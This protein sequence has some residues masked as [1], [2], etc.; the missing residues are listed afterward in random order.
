MGVGVVNSP[1]TRFRTETRRLARTLGVVVLLVGVV[2][3]VIPGLGRPPAAAAAENQS[4]WE[5][6]A[7][8]GWEVI[9]LN[10]RSDIVY[11]APV[12][13][14]AEVGDRVFVGGRFTHV[15]RGPGSTQHPQP[16]LAAFDRAS[17]E[18][19]SDFRPQIENGVYALSASPDGTRLLVGGEFTNIDG[20]PGTSGMAALDPITGEVDPT[21]VANVTNT[22]RVNSVKEIVTYGPHAYIAGE[23]THVQGATGEPRRQYRVSRLDGVTGAVDTSFDV[24]VG[25]G[26][27]WALAIPPDG[28]RLYLGGFFSS[29]NA[30]P[31]TRWFAAVD[32]A[33]G[34]SVIPNPDPLTKNLDWVFDL[35]AT[36]DHVY[37]AGELHRMWVH[38]ASDLE[39]VRLY[40][41]GGYG[42][43]Y[44]ALHLAGDR[45][46]AGGHFHG[47]EQELSPETLGAVA[48]PHFGQA[49]WVSEWDTT[50]ARPRHGFAPRLDMREGVWALLVDSDGKLWVGGDSTVSQGISTQGFAVFPTRD[51]NAPVNL[52][53]SRPATQ[54]SV[55]GTV[56]RWLP[57]P[58]DPR[59]ATA[60]E[61][62]PHGS[63]GL[64]GA[65]TD[66]K[67]AG[68]L[69]ECSTSHTAR[70]TNPWWQVDLGASRHLD[71]LRVHAM[72]GSD[73]VTGVPFN[74][75]LD[76]AR[77]YFSDTPLT[78]SSHEQL[79]AAANGWIT[80]GPAFRGHNEYPLEN[81]SGRY[82]RIV[83]W[84]E[85]RTLDLAEVEVYNLHGDDR[86]SELRGFGAEW[87]Y[88]DS[89]VEQ[90]GWTAPDFDDTGWSRGP[91]QLGFGD[92]DE[93]TVTSN[94]VLTTYARGTFTVD[95]PGA[96]TSVSVDVIA[97]DGAAVHVNG[98]E[99]GRVNLPDG[100]LTANTFATAAVW[101]PAENEPVS[102]LVNPEILVPGENT[103]A[104][105]VHND[106]RRGGDLSLDARVVESN[107]TPPP[108]PAPEPERLVASGDLW[109]INDSGVEVPGWHEPAFD[110]AAWNAGATPFGFGE[111]HE[112]T[113]TRNGVL[114]TFARI[115]FEVSDIAGITGMEMAVIRDD[116][117]AVY[118]NGT[119]VWR[120]NLPDGPLTAG[121]FATAGVWGAPE[122]TPIVVALDPALLHEG[123]NTL[124]V[125]VHNDR[126]LGAD[127]GFDAE[128]LATR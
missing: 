99:I 10:D 3:S 122:R 73:S 94:Q 42:G 20:M 111:G 60:A 17:G 105:E 34:R 39:L 78:G 108:P 26:K 79:A 81:I 83:A 118:L 88:N 52:A 12:W 91:G 36:N 61:R 68:G 14:L 65:A 40:Q 56:L 11:P 69:W 103:L 121:T 25:G 15:R 53:R 113:V 18:W 64:A 47:W 48:N 102:F 44:Q 33:T 32:L 41:T 27:V 5:E 128:V 96:L 85:N 126:R 72:W 114:T 35:A 100:P 125:R 71:L 1:R 38:Q 30:A 106:R 21:F 95:D 50:T 4:A 8:D 74:R 19:I 6:V 116:G 46:I 97:D 110:A 90:P 123:T 76:D 23:F 66:G 43:D 98:H 127:L 77:V 115:T 84:G 92:G 109:R 75:A 67:V 120:S 22:N 16:F 59:L 124:A 104:I 37:V 112:A 13:A 51:P 82:I 119:E 31:A 29:V 55:D 86:L 45:L 62:C 9:G 54:S 89:G 57:R 70:E 80:L 63:H 107:E 7:L 58:R 117:V 28:S 24:R 49:Q 87:A 2:T 101:G 93:G